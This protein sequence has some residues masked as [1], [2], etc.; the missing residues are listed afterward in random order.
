MSTKFESPHT[1]RRRRTIVDTIL[2]TQRSTSTIEIAHLM[3]SMGYTPTD[4]TVFSV[5]EL[6]RT[7]YGWVRWSPTQRITGYHA[8][9]VTA[10][11][12]RALRLQMGYLTPAGRPCKGEAY[13]GWPEL[14]AYV[15]RAAKKCGVVRGFDWDYFRYPS[16]RGLA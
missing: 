2:R 1:K 16:L 15:F 8:P 4:G 6:L 12:E 11:E 3:R 14:Y 7:G 10:E 5:I 9:D 13:T